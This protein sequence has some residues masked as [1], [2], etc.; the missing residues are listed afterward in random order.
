MQTS[1]T[2]YFTSSR[3]DVLLSMV[4]VCNLFFPPFFFLSETESR[5]YL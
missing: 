3:V 5:H 2:F 4:V 1:N